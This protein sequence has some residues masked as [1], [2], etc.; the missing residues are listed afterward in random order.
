[1]NLIYLSWKNKVTQ[2]FNNRT[3]I[4]AIIYWTIFALAIAIGGDPSDPGGS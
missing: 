3:K 1:M 2:L 4:R